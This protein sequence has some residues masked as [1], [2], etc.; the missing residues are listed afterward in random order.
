MLSKLGYD[1]KCWI[2]Q[3]LL[4]KK[5]I[6]E[7]QGFEDFVRRNLLKVDFPLLV[8]IDSAYQ[9]GRK[10]VKEVQGAKLYGKTTDE[11]FAVKYVWYG[12]E[13]LTVFLP[14]IDYVY[15]YAGVLQA[16]LDIK[17]G[18]A[19]KISQALSHDEYYLA[20]RSNVHTDPVIF[21]HAIIKALNPEIGEAVYDELNKKECKVFGYNGKRYV[22]F[23]IEMPAVFK[24]DRVLYIYEPDSTRSN[25]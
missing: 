18:L 20:R 17:A 3:D 23:D 12:E 24:K 13:H 4:S 6:A 1:K 7:P 5:K 9:R 2:L 16:Q 14:G 11:F 25:C 22:N 21:S 10:I 15:D 8:G 19:L